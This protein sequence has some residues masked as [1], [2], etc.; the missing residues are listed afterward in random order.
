MNMRT[1]LLG[2]TAIRISV[3]TTL[4]AALLLLFSVVVSQPAL[5]LKFDGFASV[6]VLSTGGTGDAPS[7]EPGTLAD[8][9]PRIAL[10][11]CFRITPSI[12]LG[13]VRPPSRMLSHPALPQGPP[14]SH[15]VHAD[16]A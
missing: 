3:V 10:P 4:M 7:S 2:H 6:K 9:A 15:G 16:V 13:F 11:V 5:E 14:S 12:H 8:L 1:S